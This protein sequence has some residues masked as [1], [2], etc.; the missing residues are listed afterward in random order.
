[1]KEAWKSVKGFEGLYSISN[2]GRLKSYKKNKSGYILSV[3]NRHGWYLTCNLIDRDGKMVTKRIHRLVAEHFLG[4]PERMREV[5]HKD[6]NKQNNRV[7][8]LEW[9]TR[10]ENNQHAIRNKPQIIQG[11]N[12][13][14]KYIRPKKII[15]KTLDNKIVGIYANSIEAQE[16]TGVCYRNI[17]MVASKTE[18]SPNRYRSQAGGYK[19]EYLEKGAEYGD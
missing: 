17:L 1:M 8:N 13:Y 15:Q 6:M 2:F 7:D 11:M 9:V 3:K 18:Y 10:K 14:N 19:W 16:E 4:I 5:N 12:H